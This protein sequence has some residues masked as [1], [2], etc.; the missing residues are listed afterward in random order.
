VSAF[1]AVAKR[2]PRSSLPSFLTAARA[3]IVSWINCAKRLSSG[4]DL[5]AG[6]RK[7]VIHRLYGMIER[8]RYHFQIKSKQLLEEM[9]GCSRVLCSVGRTCPLPFQRPASRVRRRQIRT[10]QPPRSLVIHLGQRCQIWW[11]RPGQELGL[12]ISE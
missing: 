3:F 8:W 9:A 5:W 6:Y 4:V 12:M 7:C 2:T 1:C 10:H 11:L